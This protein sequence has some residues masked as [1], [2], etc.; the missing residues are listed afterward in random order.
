MEVGVLWATQLLLCG[1]VMNSMLLSAK[2]DGTGLIK[3]FR[4]HHLMN[5]FSMRVMQNI[6]WL[7]YH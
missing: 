6:M 2:V 5:G 7:G 4:R 3:E 1:M